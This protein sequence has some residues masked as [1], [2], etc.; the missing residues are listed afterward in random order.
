MD[1]SV[2]FA[3]QFA[4]LLWLL[5]HEPGNVNEQKA[6]LRL[7]VTTS[8]LGAV[9]L[10]SQ[11][12]DLTANN[13][14]V[15]SSLTGVSDVTTQMTRHG[16]ALITIDVN[17]TAA[18][19][20]GT[21]RI[22]ASMPVLG[23]GGA[24]AEAQRIALRATT[25]RFAA[26]PPVA[27]DTPVAPSI[28]HETPAAEAMEFGDVLDDPLAEALAHAAPRMTQSISAPTESRG[29]ER[30]M[31][32]QFAASRAPT[33][34][35]EV[36]LGRLDASLDSSV[37]AH[38][39]EG[40]AVHAEAAG[41]EGKPAVVSEIMFRLARREPDVEH[42]ESKR[43]FAMTLRRLAK[44]DLLRMVTRQLPHDAERRDEHVAVL[45]RAGQEGADALIE[46]IAVVAHPDD[47]RIYFETLL[48]LP[49]G[50]A[51]LLQML[52]DPR[53]SVVRN[54]ADLLGEMQVAEAE[55]PLTMLLRHD[56]ER[57]RRSATGALMKLGTP[58]ALQAIQQALLDA[59]PQ[60]R[61]QAA[62]ALVTLK[63]V[64]TSAPQLLRALD[65]E[66]DDDVQEAFL[67][68]LGKLATPE[69]V[70]RLIGAAE[71][72]RGL[73]QKR[74]TSFRVAAVNALAESRTEE[75]MAT[76]RELQ[77]DKDAD[78]RA[79]VMLALGRIARATQ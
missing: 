47:R 65:A 56:E 73:F 16:L 69:A 55:Q 31:F 9:S 33:E 29:D 35:H 12:I 77:S 32:A 2:I 51:A 71:A 43:V 25:V 21:A 36:L 24:A 1:H 67:L 4:H 42:F 14:S 27:R 66:K 8:K 13:N 28:P 75:A 39:L 61:I 78:V 34:S 22:L 10:A 45:A 59:A 5:L 76:L 68:A 72:K 17:P 18:D 63:D 62:A 20:L 3:R 41:R 23:D 46:Q 50:V 52:G 58:R 6:A 49:T 53:W 11:G 54:A 79:A 40:L 38:V 48:R 7:L 15:P 26:R 74:T 70:H 60:M 19:L 44:P 64:R 57:V 37:I 30:G